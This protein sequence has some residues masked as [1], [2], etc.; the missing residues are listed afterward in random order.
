MLD[1]VPKYD[2]R[3]ISLEAYAERLETY[4]GI[5]PGT[6]LA[7]HES[8]LLTMKSTWPP[9]DVPEEKFWCLMHA[10]TVSNLE[11]H[12]V[13]FGIIGNMAAPGVNE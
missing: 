11:K 3:T 4:C 2:P 10:V 5:D 12:G 8:G 9:P 7:V 13:K 1:R 6:Y